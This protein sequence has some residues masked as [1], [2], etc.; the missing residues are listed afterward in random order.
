MKRIIIGAAVVALA[1]TGCTAQVAGTDVKT[2]GLPD[3]RTVL[4]VVVGSGS[5]G[6][7]SIDCDWDSAK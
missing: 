1:L 5:S 6:A 3:G 4:C 7:V 2:I